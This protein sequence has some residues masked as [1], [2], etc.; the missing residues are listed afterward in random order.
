LT[1]GHRID[2]FAQK[3]LSF[4]GIADFRSQALGSPD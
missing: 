3:G 2:R 4:S 1:D